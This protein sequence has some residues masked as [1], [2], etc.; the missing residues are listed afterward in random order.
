MPSPDRRHGIAVYEHPHLTAADT[1]QML[2]MKARAARRTDT[3]DVRRL[4]T[5]TGI[6]TLERIEHLVTDTF[7]T[8]SLPDRQRRW[9]QALLR[10]TSL[11]EGYVPASV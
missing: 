10:D 7:P 9:L 5:I 11:R 8:R 4:V 2:A 6:N 1:A 3:Q